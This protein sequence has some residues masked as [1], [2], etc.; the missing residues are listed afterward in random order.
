MAD[1]HPKFVV[2]YVF[3]GIGTLITALLMSLSLVYVVKINYSSII[4][5]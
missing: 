5:Y 4:Y 1:I 3:N 2:M